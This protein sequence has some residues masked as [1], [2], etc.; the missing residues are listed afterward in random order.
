MINAEEGGMDELI[1]GKFS[2]EPATGV[3][4]NGLLIYTFTRGGI[5]A[6]D[7]SEEKLPALVQEIQRIDTIRLYAGADL[8][9]WWMDSRRRLS[10]NLQRTFNAM[11]MEWKQEKLLQAVDVMRDIEQELLQIIVNRP[12]WTNLIITVDS[13]VDRTLPILRPKA[14][15]GYR[16]L[17]AALGWPPSLSKSPRLN[18]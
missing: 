17:L 1:D 4:R 13:R 8:L 7:G 14:L 18:E 12:Q 15:T 11:E 10:K 9:S 2:S 16:A 3:P 6:G 5:G